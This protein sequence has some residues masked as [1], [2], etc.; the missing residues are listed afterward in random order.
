MTARNGR[1]GNR[2]PKPAAR[3][4]RR[5]VSVDATGAQAAAD[6]ADIRSPETHVG[7]ARAENF[8]FG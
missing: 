8:L 7:H 6:G 1:S 5:P 2:L 3:R 4:R